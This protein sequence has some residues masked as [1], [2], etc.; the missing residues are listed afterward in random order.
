MIP[1]PLPSLS[2][3]AE[4]TGDEESGVAAVPAQAPSVAR[5]YDY[6]LGGKDNYAADREMAERVLDR[7]PVVARLAQVNRGFLEYAAGLL[8]ESGLRQFVDVGCGLPAERNVGDMVRRAAPSCRVAYVDN[9]PLVLVH[10]RA[11]L[12]VDRGTGAFGGD[13]RAPAALLAH[14][15]LRRLIDFGRPVAVLLLGVLD[16]VTDE[17]DPRGI[18]RT[19]LDGLPPGSHMVVT[20]TERTPALEALAE[21][22]RRAGLAFTPRRREEIAEICAPL[23]PVGR[24]PAALPLADAAGL[25]GP[26]PLVGCIGRKRV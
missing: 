7:A 9:D 17:E 24:Y 8:A 3:W 26:L 2:R 21:T 14:P 5:M 4:L 15:G 16:F 22:A 25:D 23:D 18:V 1:G 19:L 6:Y 12:A 11:L 10:A 20:H 13:V